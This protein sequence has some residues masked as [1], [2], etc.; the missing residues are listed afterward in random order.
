MEL[1]EPHIIS[2]SASVEIALCPWPVGQ[3]GN[4]RYNGAN[5]MEHGAAAAL[6]RRRVYMP[7]HLMP[8]WHPSRFARDIGLGSLALDYNESAFGAKPNVRV[9]NPLQDVPNSARDC[10]TLEQPQCFRPRLFIASYEE[11][12]ESTDLWG[13]LIKR[14][15]IQRARMFDQPSQERPRRRES[16]LRIAPPP[17][18][19]DSDLGQHR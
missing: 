3:C 9:G 2:A 17:I 14:V 13:T 18:L 11:F 15:P 6:V 8:D 12:S 10:F 5:C 19:Q 16:S 1:L 4:Q 7:E